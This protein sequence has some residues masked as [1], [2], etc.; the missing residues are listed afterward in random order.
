M[1]P[2]ERNEIEIILMA[3]PRKKPCFTSRL[4]LAELDAQVLT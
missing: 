2:T 3:S 4:L 1:D